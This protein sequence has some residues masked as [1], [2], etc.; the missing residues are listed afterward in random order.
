MRSAHRSQVRGW[1]TALLATLALLAL[2]AG[3][4]AAA[5]DDKYGTVAVIDAATGS[6]NI[7]GGEPQVCDFYFAFD[8]NEQADVLGWVVKT[9]NATPLAGTTV[10]SGKDGPTD[11]DGQ[12]RQ[13]DSGSLS[14]PDGRYNVIWDDES[15]VDSSNGHQSFTVSCEASTPTPTPTPT[16]TA[17]PTEAPTATPTATPTGGVLPATG[18]P[19]G[20]PAGG[21]EAATGSA[22]V[23]LPPTDT[24]PSSAGGDATAIMLMVAGLGLLGFALMTLV[25]T[26]I[27]ARKPIRRR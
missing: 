3:P 17:A 13:P 10:L 24:D 1:L 16:A 21:V 23:T 26:W 2:M 11:A 25:P 8:L 12:L 14:L 5:V 18:A 20:T 7:V 4:A 15:P 9:W 19:T 6:E 27:A 22:R